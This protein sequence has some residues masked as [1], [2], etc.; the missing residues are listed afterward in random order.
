MGVSISIA[1]A[2]PSE[3]VRGKV[4]T[5][6]EMRAAE[7]EWSVRKVDLAF[8]KGTLRQRGRSS[9]LETPRASGVSLLPHFACEEL[10]F[11]FLDGSGVLVE[12]VVENVATDTPT[13]LAEVIVKTQ[14]AGPVV[15]REICE[16]LRGISSRFAP[17][18]VIDDETG[19]AASGD[20][21]GLRRAFAEA[22][23][24]I[25]AKVE[26]DR[27]GPG[28]AF[29]VGEFPFE[30]PTKRT[31]AE[32]AGL[33][34]KERGFVLSCEASFVARFGG[35]G[36]N[37]DHSRTSVLDLELAIS[38]VDGPDVERDPGRP[39]I[40]DLTLQAGAYFGRTVAAAVG[41]AWRVDDGRFLLA[42]VG[43]SGLLVDPFEVARDRILKGPPYSFAYHLDVYETIAKE[44]GRDG[45]A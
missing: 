40:Q 13:F 39:E 16:L 28:A 27:H 35:F 25:R 26:S 8:R 10:P 29:Q 2:V 14:F 7:Q 37:L 24:A 5:W 30:V 31:G 4:L 42:D 1:G 23:A 18:L 17:D 36:T 6:L 38:D 44:L 9:P 11:V 19:F 15:H 45:S 21:A 43:R 41:G 12:E 22:W 33:S 20:E 34:E 32:L 3:D